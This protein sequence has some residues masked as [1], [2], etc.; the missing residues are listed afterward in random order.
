MAWGAIL[1]ALGQIGGGLVSANGTPKP[2]DMVSSYYNPQ[3]DYAL[4]AAQFD[5]LNQIG[6]GNLGNIPDPFQQIAGQLQNVPLDAKTRRRAMVALQNIKQDPTLLEDP[7]GLQYTRDQ[8]FEANKTGNVPFGRVVTRGPEGSGIWN[9]KQAGG[10]SGATKGGMFTGTTTGDPVAMLGGA[11]L[12]GTGLGKKFLESPFAP[13]NSPLSKIIFKDL[14][15]VKGDTEPT[16]L[17]VKNIGRLEQALGAAG[18]NLGDLAKKMQDQKDFE[19]KIARLKAAGLPQLAEQMVIDR[20]KTSATAAG[21]AAAGADYASTGTSQNP[22]F[23]QLQAQ[24]QRNL[25]R[26]ATRAGLQAN[27]GGISQAAA[28]KQISDAELDQNLRVL[29]NALATSGLLQA[30]LAPGTAAVQGASNSGQFN[31]AQIAAQQAQ[32]ANSLRQAGGINRADSIGNAIGA[33]TS[34]LGTYLSNQAA[35]RQLG[36]NGSLPTY[37]GGMYGPGSTASQMATN[38]N[39]SYSGLFGNY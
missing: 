12:G 29:Q 26:F 4:Q 16:G 14:F 34:T 2:S 6:W 5:A 23:Q 31:A 32:A 33:A 24:D 17:Q 8:V 25:D 1:G 35:Q 9:T 15:G 22:L 13:G 20:A 39:S 21:L 28:Q 11:V 37:E 38:P 18:M 36:G 30:T 10:M 7:Y 3:M 19:A 27:F